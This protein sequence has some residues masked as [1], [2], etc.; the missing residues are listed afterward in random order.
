MQFLLTNQNM[1]FL[2]DQRNLFPGLQNLSLTCCFLGT[3]IFLLWDVFRHIKCWSHLLHHILGFMYAYK[4]GH[5]LGGVRKQSFCLFVLKLLSMFYSLI[6][7]LISAIYTYWIKV[8]IPSQIYL[9]FLIS[10]K[11]SL[12]TGFPYILEWLI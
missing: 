1:Y 4:P 6:Y 8:L 2:K 10:L 3:V 11:S 7:A 12:Y 9:K 5:R